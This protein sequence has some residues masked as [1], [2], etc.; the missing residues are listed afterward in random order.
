MDNIDSRTLPVEARN[1]RCLRAVK[2]RLERVSV[3]ETAAQGELSPTVVIAALKAFHAG[4][5]TAVVVHRPGRPAGTGR[6]LSAE[7]EREV[8]RLIRNRTPDPLKVVNAPWTREAAVELIRD[9]FGLKLPVRAMGLPL[10]RWA[11][12]PQKPTCKA[13]RQ[14]PAAV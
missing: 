2:M 14:S 8:R 12:R 4:G 7:Q 11:R 9:R 5:W 1:E 13:C 3:K 10:E 6:R